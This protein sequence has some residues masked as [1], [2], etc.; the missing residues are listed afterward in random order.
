MTDAVVIA[1]IKQAFPDHSQR[2]FNKE[3]SKFFFNRPKCHKTTSMENRAV[4]AE[5]LAKFPALAEKG[6]NEG[7][8]HDFDENG[9]PVFA[10]EAEA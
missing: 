9:D 4:T 1:K 10:T 5:D 8:M 7:D 2:E 3:I 6:I